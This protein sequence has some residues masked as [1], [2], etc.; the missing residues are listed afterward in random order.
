MIVRNLAHMLS[1][2]CIAT[3]LS[4]LAG[5]C[6]GMAA[7]DLSAR[8]QFNIAPQELPSALLR[9]SEQSGVQV[10]SPAEQLDGKVT[11]GVVGTF[12]ARQALER[13]LVGT[14]LNYGVIGSNTVTI[15]VPGAA[16]RTD[17][18]THASSA[19]PVSMSSSTPPSGAEGGQ[20]K[21]SFWD[22]FR[23]AQVDREKTASDARVEETSAAFQAAPAKLE[24]IVVTAQK[25]FERLQDVPVPVTAIS[26]DS[27]VSNNQLRLQDYYSSVPGL[28]LTPSVQAAQALT[29]RGISTGSVTN[30]TV[31]VTVD[32][33]PYGS[34]TGL[35]GGEVVPDIDPNDLARIE[36]LRGPQGALY[37]ASS[38][39]GLLKFV[40][41]DPS[42]ERT[43][44]RMEV[45]ASG[46]SNGADAGYNLRGSVNV[47]LNETIAVRAS[48]FTRRDPG[49]IDNPILHINGLNEAR[50]SGGRVSMSWRPSGLLSVKLSALFQ[51]AKGDGSNDVGIPTASYSSTSGLGDLQQNY[52]RN[53][54]S[55]DRKVE[56]YSAILDARLGG[57][58]LTSVTGYNV[59][60]LQD[61]FDLSFALGGAALKV[62]GVG[63]APVTD[64]TSTRKFSQEIRLS[65]PLGEKY[66]W[67]IGGFYT[68]EDS[69]YVQNVLAENPATGEVAGSLGYS[70]FPTTYQ[71]YAGFTDLTVH[72]TDR[73]DVQIGGRDSEIDQTYIDY[74]ATGAIS[75]PKASSRANAT[76][77][78][79]TPR[80]K[81]SPDLMIYARAASGYRAG[82]PNSNC[83]ENNVP[84]Q[85]APDKTQNYEVGVKGIFLDG[86][87]TIDS[88]LYY[89][90]WK[91]IQLHLV[92]P[93]NG[94]GYYTNGGAAR[95]K[96]LEFSVETRP[97]TG[98]TI[99]AW[100]TWNEAT[101][102]QD[103]PAASTAFGRSG[104]RL[105]LSS[106]FS[107]NLSLQQE[108]P[109]WGSVAGFAGANLN[110]VGSRKG[111]FVGDPQRSDLPAYTKTDL[112]VG[113]KYES[114][115]V[116]VYVNNVADRRG[117]LNGGLGYY[118][119]FAS[120]YIQP[121][122][123]G[124]NLSRTF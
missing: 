31:G 98:L 9:Y 114:W 15:F 5:I 45:G 46:V 106:R 24:E 78:L 17:S 41:A 105:P 94:D 12:S 118:P 40:T 124:L 81:M 4:L 2:F 39:G 110:F 92:N 109:L 49:Y 104:D 79:V 54:G 56:A 22:R 11:A 74:D 20:Q 50:V 103:L 123:F 99:A 76:T 19:P 21:P 25:R 87:L 64:D 26:A 88:S 80:F 58:D 38:L 100:V 3:C 23:V 117:V 6:P 83:V 91:N 52:V 65:I 61:S 51:E 57:V 82:G 37:G 121:R 18:S 73:F 108:F 42:T 48:A 115:I 34:S 111:D 89:I 60:S 90:D 85:Y 71:E 13:L 53:V 29:I 102:T 67:L 8:A 62:F 10:T 101:L 72:F 43:S 69:P 96:G 28:N 70:K 59:N 75:I 77:Y 119:P 27:L 33:V 36:V 68:H 84:C 1:R 93:Q 112:R 113:G 35:G 32:D 122:T 55:Y 63:G 95:S 116:N 66:E 16:G 47:P 120:I 14:A 7:A 44:G 30:P 97:V 86:R 107:G